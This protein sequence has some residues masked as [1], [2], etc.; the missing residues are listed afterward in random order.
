MTSKSGGG[1]QGWVNLCRNVRM[2]V[3]RG[4]KFRPPPNLLIVAKRRRLEEK[5]GS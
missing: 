3:L 4:R 2:G 5:G 1:W